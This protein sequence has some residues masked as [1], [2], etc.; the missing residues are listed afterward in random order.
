MNVGPSF[1]VS[2]GDLCAVWHVYSRESIYPTSECLQIAKFRHSRTKRGK[3]EFNGTGER[4][5]H[6]QWSRL[7][8]RKNYKAPL[9]RKEKRS[10]SDLDRKLRDFI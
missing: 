7:P 6:I 8:H 1:E 4:E 10:R 9:N 2:F 3:E 5:S